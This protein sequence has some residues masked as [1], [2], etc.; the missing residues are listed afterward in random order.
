[1]L[2]RGRGGVRIIGAARRESLAAI[3]P[4][5]GFFIIAW[6]GHPAGAPAS[7]NWG[8]APVTE[9]GSW[10]VAVA[11][12]TAGLFTCARRWRGELGLPRP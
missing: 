1:L 10:V 2:G 6:F 12:L 8:Q 3:G 9:A 11:L 7:W 4:L 5:A